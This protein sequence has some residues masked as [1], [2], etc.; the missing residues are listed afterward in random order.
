MIPLAILLEANRDPGLRGRVFP[1]DAS[2]LRAPLV[3]DGQ[4]VGFYCPHVAKNGRMRLGP[5]YITPEYRQRGLMTEV[6]EGLRGTPM[7]AAILDWNDGTR[8]LHEKVGFVK[9]KRFS[10]GWHYVRD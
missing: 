7:M 3:A 8:R 2:I 1:H 5:I 9:W 6:Y 10:N 4:V